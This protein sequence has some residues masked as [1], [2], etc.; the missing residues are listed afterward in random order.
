M[1][2]E[3]QSTCCLVSS[4][5]RT[6]SGK[7]LAFV[8]P[9][10]ELLS[11]LKWKQ[12][13]GTGAI[14]MSPT[15]ELALQTYGVVSDLATAHNLTYGLVMGGA[16]RKSEATRLV[17]GISIVIAT[18]G[19]LLDHLQ[20]TKGFLFENLQCLVID[21]ADRILQIGFEEDMKSILKLL[22]KQRQTVLFSATQ[23]KDVQGLAKLSL[24][25]RFV[26]TPHVGEPCVRRCG[27]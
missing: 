16:N 6:G 18:P 24:S 9:T 13:Q 12:R 15:R 4:I 21:E 22:P 17:K 20:N 1:F 5:F 23:D 2:L 26:A 14:I 27:R 7:T 8:I 3:Q 25:V 19:R 10:I 11:R